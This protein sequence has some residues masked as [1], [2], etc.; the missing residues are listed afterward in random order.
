MGSSRGGGGGGGGSRGG[1]KLSPN[2]APT[3]SPGLPGH[4]RLLPAAVIQEQEREPNRDRM[5]EG[6]PSWEIMKML[7]NGTGEFPAQPEVKATTPPTVQ[8][9]T[10]RLGGNGSQSPQGAPSGTPA[11]NPTQT[12]PTTSGGST[13]PPAPQGGSVGTEASTPRKDVLASLGSQTPKGMPEGIS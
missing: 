11:P 8:G 2:F 3:T 6:T 5:I 12:P 10:G 1:Q 7:D 13:A 4:E 9:A